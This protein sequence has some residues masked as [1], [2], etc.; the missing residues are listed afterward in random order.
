MYTVIHLHVDGLLGWPPWVPQHSTG[1]DGANNM[2]PVFW[3]LKTS[4]KM[5]CL[6]HKLKV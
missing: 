6:E 4:R 5:K 1:E 2:V 3:N